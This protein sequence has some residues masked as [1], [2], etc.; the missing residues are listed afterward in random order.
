MIEF[1]LT[2]EPTIRLSI[3]I[4]ML[5]LMVTWEVIAPKRRRLFSR[6]QRWPNNFGIVI[7]N[8][9]LIRLIFPIAAVGIA[10]YAE[11]RAWGV[12]NLVELPTALTIFFAVIV[13]DLVIYL[14]HVVFHKIPVLWR[15]H[16]MHHSDLDFDVTTGARFH[17]IE[18]ILSM[19]IKFAAVILLGAPAVAVV[20]FEVLLNA[21]A[22][23]NHSNVQLPASFDRVLRL[24]IVTPDMHRVHHSIVREETDSNFGFNIPWWDRLFRTYCA[25]PKAGH[26]NMT[27][28]IDQFQKA[29]YLR[30]DKLLIQ[31]FLRNSDD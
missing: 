14:Q 9:L 7:V 16:R 24:I 15:L 28:G 26:T 19:V 12:L 25:Q 4:G 18:I 20:I 6:W 11:E 2:H 21:A 29:K 10:I 31:P 1:I 23:F 3:F 13:L 17:P 30:L 5:A 8:T 27:I 22:M